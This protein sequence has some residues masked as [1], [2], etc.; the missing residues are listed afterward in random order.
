[1]QLSYDDRSGVPPSWTDLYY[2][3]P[4]TTPY[5]EEGN[6]TRYP[7]RESNF[8]NPLEATL[9]EHMQESFQLTTN[10]FIQ[11]DF[12][13]VQGLNYRLNTSFRK[14]FYDSATYRGRN[15]ATGLEARGSSDE[16]EI[17]WNNFVLE[18]I[19]TYDRQF[20]KH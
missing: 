7:W 18:N 4:L 6:L 1:T 17:R 5:D 11:V 19:L 13:F 14:R 10:N 3:N 9:Y 20:A 16:T 15:T 12:P 2:M 8:N